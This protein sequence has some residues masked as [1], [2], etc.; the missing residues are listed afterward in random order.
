M[1]EQTAG[2]AKLVW[3]HVE[4]EGGIVGDVQR[5]R[6]PGG[7]LL[8]VK[9]AAQGLVYVPDI[10]HDWQAQKRGGGDKPPPPPF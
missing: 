5:A 8:A 1:P 2:H 9:G 4:Q 3:E 10:N 7:W 6:V